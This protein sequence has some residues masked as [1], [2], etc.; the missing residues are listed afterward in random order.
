MRARLLFLPNRVR[1][2]RVLTHSIPPHTLNTLHI[3][4]KP[5]PCLHIN[6]SPRSP[7]PDLPSRAQ[8]RAPNLASPPWTYLPRL[9]NRYPPHPGVLHLPLPESH[10]PHHPHPELAKPPRARLRTRAHQHHKH[11]E[12]LKKHLPL[13]QPNE[14]IRISQAE[15]VLSH[16]GRVPPRSSLLRLE[17]RYL[18]SP[19]LE[20]L[21]YLALGLRRFGRLGR[22][23]LNLWVL[24]VEFGRP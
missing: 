9:G 20:V 17:N 2:N 1:T 24:G 6:H 7:V 3:H 12:M 11:Y 23:E 10:L 15:R 22:V 5:R 19:R 4:N 13:H 14:L 18:E 21:N 8:T 16:L